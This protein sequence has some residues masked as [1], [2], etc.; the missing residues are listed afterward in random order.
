[1]YVHMQSVVN[2]VMFPLRL[3]S[4]IPGTVARDKRYSQSGCFW[5]ALPL[6]MGLS[7]VDSD[8]S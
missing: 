2:L 4:W 7:R 8:T 6:T 5:Q 1:M 3:D